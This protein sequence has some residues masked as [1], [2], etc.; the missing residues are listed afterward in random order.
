MRSFSTTNTQALDTLSTPSQKKVYP[1]RLLPVKTLC[2]NHYFTD[3]EIGLHNLEYPAY[4]SDHYP[5]YTLL[6]DYDFGPRVLVSENSSFV[7]DKFSLAAFAES[8]QLTL[9]NFFILQQVDTPI[10]LHQYRSKFRPEFEDPTSRL[11]TMLSSHGKQPRIRLWLLGALSSLTSDFYPRATSMGVLSD[12]YPLLTYILY[13][14]SPGYSSS[15]L[16]L[17][18]TEWE[19]IPFF[20]S[21]FGHTLLGDDVAPVNPRRV[22]SILF[23]KLIKH[24]P[25]FAMK[26]KKV[27]KM[28]YK[29]SRGKSG[30]Y[31]VEWKYIPRYKRL[32]VVLRWLVD[33]VRFQKAPTF[34]LQLLR[35]LRLFLA[36]PSE[37]L[38][39]RNRGYVHHNV[40]AKYKNSLLRSLKKMN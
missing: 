4:T 18:P 31:T 9:K 32:N 10:V 6:D 13:S 37:H 30:K 11:V 3:T 25:I 22:D 38:V 8:R 5:H 23:E 12:S 27:D 36:T 16:K 19:T 1:A 7:E 20:G 14:S 34:Q 2:I 33:D 26:T 21:R 15:S 40:Y 35:S 39:G 28:R 17:S 24:V 29:H